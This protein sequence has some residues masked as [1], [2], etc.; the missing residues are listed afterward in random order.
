MSHSINTKKPGTLKLLLAVS[1]PEFLPAN[2]ASLIIGLAWGLTL[3]VDVFWG[4]ALPLILAF[5]TL[6]FVGAF[7]AHINT[8][9]DYE[10][11]QKMTPRKSSLH[12]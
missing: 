8:Y 11:D 6:S 2:S 4:G 3:P 10:L 7:A 12:P 9:A 5:A 1:R